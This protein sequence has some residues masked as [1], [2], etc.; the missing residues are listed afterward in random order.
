MRL[1]HSVSHIFPIPKGL[2]KSKK[3]ANFSAFK[4][5]SVGNDEVSDTVEGKRGFIHTT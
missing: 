2:K 1:F 3:K 5:L 4:Q